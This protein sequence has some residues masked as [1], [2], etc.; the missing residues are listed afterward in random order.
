MAVRILAL[1]I[2]LAI[3][4]PQLQMSRTAALAAQDVAASVP[5]AAQPTWSYETR[6][7]ADAAVTRVVLE[8]PAQEAMRTIEA[9]AVVIA[10]SAVAA[11]VTPQ[12]RKAPQRRATPK[13]ARAAS[14]VKLVGTAATLA[15]AG[16]PPGVHCA[17]VVVAKVTPVLR[18]PL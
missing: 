15:D 18:R 16:C 8:L 6:R 13:L 1:L 7:M 11:D 5:S 14:R 2:P 17:P 4:L 10:D 9:P 12:V 3:M